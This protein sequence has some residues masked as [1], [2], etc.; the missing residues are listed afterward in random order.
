MIDP[1]NFAGDPAHLV[2]V[3]ITSPFIT[4]EREE[5]EEAFSITE[6]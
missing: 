3:G 5:R 1:V 2:P 4:N 6:S